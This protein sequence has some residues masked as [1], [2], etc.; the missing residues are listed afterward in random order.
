MTMPNTAT[1]WERPR[2]LAP[3]LAVS[4]GAVGLLTLLLEVGN[5][6]RL[7]HRAF[8][9]LGC[10][11]QPPLLGPALVLVVVAVWLAEAAGVGWSRWLLLGLVLAPV[12]WL[13]FL[14]YV[15]VAPIFAL[16][17][18]GW[19]AYTGTAA[20]SRAALV[21][22]LVALLPPM[23]IYKEQP[24]D[25][26]TWLL[27]AGIS[28]TTARALANQ[29]R[30][31]A[32]LRA[33]QADLARQAAAEERRRIV[34][35]IHDVVAHSLAVTML[36]L[37]AARHILER[38]PR[39]AAEALAEAERLG[40]Q[41]LADIR[42]TVGLLRAA[43]EE[44]AAPPLPSATD[45]PELIQSFAAAGLDVRLRSD[46][47]AGRLSAAAGLGLYRIV[48][49]ALANAA[50][51]APGAPVEVE[52]TVGAATT[53]VRVWNPRAGEPRAPA[54]EPGLGVTGMRERAELLGG[55]LRAGPDGEGWC[56]EAT[57]PVVAPEAVTV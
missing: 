35:E 4:A 20:E 25:W 57:I 33:A 16:L 17:L 30:L 37:T 1:S 9:T 50:K 21:L 13:L 56:V 53:T 19:L 7:C 45:L 22:A 40:R 31:L 3:A 41:S 14:G 10:G 48:Q 6:E 44:G 36:H 39:Q 49:E 18:G 42:R 32:E 47:D 46:G 55:D 2:W 38:D 12:F 24:A 15:L 27:G 34:R 54:G 23:L 28:W 51:H 29:Q 8:N 5:A 26:I 11:L 43:P 52:L